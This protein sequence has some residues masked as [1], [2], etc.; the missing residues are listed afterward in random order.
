MSNLAQRAL[1]AIVALPLLGALIWW[2]QPLGFGVL[3]LVI[4]GLAL[5]E[6]LKITLPAV[7]IRLRALLIA[8]GVGLSA[9]LYLAPGLGLVWAA[10]AFMATAAIVLLDPGEISGAASRLGLAVFGVF[11]LGVLTAPLAILQRDAPSGRTWVLLAIALTFG[12]DTGAYFAG[13]ALGRHKLYPSVSP[14]KTVEGAVGGLVAGLIV[15]FLARATIVPWLTVRDCLLVAIPAAVVGPVGD[16]VESLV[17]RASGVKDSG[18]IIPG[19]GG[20]LDRIDA[21][22]FVAAWTYVYVLHLRG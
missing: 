21:L 14:G 4:A 19:H 12:N 8:L 13:R 9:G 6:Y 18:H 7:S 1:S 17:K 2:R 10:A 20:V 5:A 16:L 11:Y 15:M 3:V 22:L